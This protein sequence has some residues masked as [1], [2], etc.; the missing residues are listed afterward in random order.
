MPEVERLFAA[1]PR[2]RV[3]RGGSTDPEGRCV[4]YWAQ[5]SQRGRENLALDLA[6]EIGNALALPVMAVFGLTAD[7]PGAQRRH[8][9]FLVEALP[10]VAGEM[11]ARGVPL[12]V[13]IGRPDAV[14]LAVSREAG[15]ALVVGDENPL[16]VGQEWR[17]RLSEALTIPFVCVDSD[18]VVPTSLFPKEEYAARTIRPKI[19]RV[20]ASYLKPSTNPSA[21]ARWKPRD[22]P[23][24]E[25]LDPDT[26]VARLKVGGVGE[27]AG[28][29]GG[30][31]EARR[32]LAR[33]V[34]DRL[35]RYAEGR[36]EPVPYATCE[37]SAHLHFGHISPVTIA[38]AVRESGA[39]PE[40]IESFIEELVVRRELAINFV[41]RNPHYDDLGGCPSWALA[42]L[43]KHAGDPRP[44]LYGT[45]A[46]EASETHDPLWNAAQKEM[47]LTGRMHNYLRMYWAKKV[48]EWTPD[49]AT[50]FAVAIDLNDRYE[51]DG[52][53]PNGY[54]GVAWAIGGRH[55]RPW[56][57]RPVFGTIRS[58]TYEGA[59][60]K[61]D[62]EAY[63]A[64][65]RSVERN[66]PT[67]AGR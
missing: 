58:M 6:V 42:T 48:L 32:R 37:L 52:R 46:L 39:P 16:R 1:G 5:R 29:R 41:A 65:V 27:V 36:N 51:M 34:S 66:A 50:A 21:R 7:Y 14:V 2:V 63:I 4:V 31:V 44:F 55:D 67:A 11:Q 25:D 49:P 43:T 61:F 12:V 62:T 24:G 64:Y 60:R 15:A 40:C 19:G 17:T 57:E 59:R 30:P 10:E 3:V 54:T 35:P 38:L 22:V 56:P 20:I 33:F 23:G 13:R 47:V 26:L 8:Y 18:V 45:A 28:Y 9:R 53:D